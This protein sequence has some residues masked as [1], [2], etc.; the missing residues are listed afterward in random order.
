M[1]GSRPSMTGEG[2]TGAFL[3][4]MAGPRAEHL[5]CRPSI[6]KESPAPMANEGIE[7]QGGS[8]AW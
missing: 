1:L 6:E 7:P 8:M 3:I 4:I 5:S 2:S